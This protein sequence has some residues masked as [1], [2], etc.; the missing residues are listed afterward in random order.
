MNKYF[1]IAPL[2]IILLVFP[3]LKKIDLYFAHLAQTHFQYATSSFVLFFYRY[4]YLICYVIVFPALIGLIG[5]CFLR[6]WRSYLPVYLYFILSLTVGGG[7]IINVALKHH[8]PRPRPIQVKQYALSYP[9][10]YPA[11]SK[12]QGYSDNFRSFPS[13]HVAAGAFLISI[14]FIGKRYQNK[15]LKKIGIYSACFFTASLSGTRILQMG[16]Y[17]SDTLAS[18]IIMWYV[19]L[20]FDWL[21]LDRFF[22]YYH[23]KNGQLPKN[24]LE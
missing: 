12:K 21:I 5:S 3:F 19:C 7:I 8:W 2:F 10:I 22:L 15:A 11:F 18:A 23:Q 16:H 6:R 14:Y 20:A 24:T 1:W 17:F 9:S 13:G 4:G